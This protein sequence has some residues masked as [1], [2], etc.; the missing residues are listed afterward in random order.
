MDSGQHS[1]SLTLPPIPTPSSPTSLCPLGQLA[2]QGSFKCLLIPFL[3]LLLIPGLQGSQPWE[4]PQSVSLTLLPL[5]IQKWEKVE[6]DFMMVTGNSSL[7]DRQQYGATW[8]TGCWETRM[9]GIL[10]L[11]SVACHIF[12]VAFGDVN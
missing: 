4:L 11:F 3:P 12:S 8:G 10:L 1:K 5:G 2:L 6:T 7:W 9:A